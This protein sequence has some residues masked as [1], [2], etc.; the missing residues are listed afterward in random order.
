VAVQRVEI[1]EHLDENPGLKP[2]VPDVL[3]QAYKTA[4]IDL[5]TRFLR[6][7]DPQPPTMCPW[8]FEQVIDEQFWP[9]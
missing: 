7:S 3:A 4:R 8:T 2:S 1:L 9:E 6:R 5:V